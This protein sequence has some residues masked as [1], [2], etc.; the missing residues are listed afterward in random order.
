MLYSKFTIT[1]YWYDLCHYDNHFYNF[2]YTLISNDAHN[3]GTIKIYCS[4]VINFLM[5]YLELLLHDWALTSPLHI[6]AILASKK[7][8]LALFHKTTFIKVIY[9]VFFSMQSPVSSQWS[10]K[11]VIPSMNAS[12]QNFILIF[13]R[14]IQR[15]HIHRIFFDCGKLLN[16]LIKK[17]LHR[18][19]SKYSIFIDASNL[20]LIFT[21]VRNPFVAS[22]YINS[23]ALVSHCFIEMHKTV[24]ITHKQ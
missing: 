22:F 5:F 23:K 24:M 9:P 3:N 21:S 10:L 7:T 19:F 13:T 4:F 12:N 16:V 18:N 6:I 1:F 20:F 2:I 8:F 15:L 17:K 11:C 14:Q